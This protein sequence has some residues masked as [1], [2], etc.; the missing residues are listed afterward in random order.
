MCGESAFAVVELVQ[1]VKRDKCVDD[2]RLFSSRVKAM[3]Y[4]QSRYAE[5]VSAKNSTCGILAASKS[6][7]GWYDIVD[8]DGDRFEAYLSEKLKIAS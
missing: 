5:I 8:G 1:E 7:D 3:Q 6:D 4:L 2:T